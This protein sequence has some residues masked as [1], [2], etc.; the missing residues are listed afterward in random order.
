LSDK[1]IDFRRMAEAEFVR[2]SEASVEDYARSMA[3]NFVRPIEETRI[4]AR[5]QVKGLLK[6]GAHTKGHHMFAVID[7]N[8]GDE[9]GS[10]WVY[11]DDEKKQAF[12]YDITIA[13]QHRRKGYGRAVMESLERMAKQMNATS[14]ALHVFADN[15][16][17]IR[18]Y[19]EQGYRTASFNM[20]KELS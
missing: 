12:L 3:R 19:Q 16:A 5:K 14:I 13:A 8:T 9:V 6:Q 10:V 18:L 4:E 20:H 7:K 11:V 15:P 2:Y 17:A 1:K